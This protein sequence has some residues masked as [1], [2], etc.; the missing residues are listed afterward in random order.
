M[1]AARGLHV[2]DSSAWLEYFFDTTRA[3]LFAA[4][5]E[6]PAHLVVPVFTLYEVFKKVLR[7]HGEAAALQVA[8]QMQQGELVHFDDGLAL[9]AAQLPLPL[10]DSLIYATAQRYGATLWTEDKHF[11]GLAGVRYFSKPSTA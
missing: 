9:E 7:T 11:E 1:A 3:S 5:I 10:A 2:V 8:A 4:T 6:D